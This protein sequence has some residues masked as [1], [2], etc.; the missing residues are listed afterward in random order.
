M[1]KTLKCLEG[2]NETANATWYSVKRK[3]K[4]RASTMEL[5]E[6]PKHVLTKKGYNVLADFLM[7]GRFDREQRTFAILRL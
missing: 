5:K 7:G 4:G 6:S 3:G 2:T 1:T